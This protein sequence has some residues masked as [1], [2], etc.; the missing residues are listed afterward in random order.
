MT[1]FR[2]AGESILIHRSD[3]IL[4]MKPLPSEAQPQLAERCLTQ[5][6][7]KQAQHIFTE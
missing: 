6:I 2:E 5:Q 4:K 3:E 7:Q 1:S